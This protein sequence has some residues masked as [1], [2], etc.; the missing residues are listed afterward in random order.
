[1]GMS[2][3]AE[4]EQAGNLAKSWLSCWPEVFKFPAVPNDARATTYLELGNLR[5]M[6]HLELP[7]FERA[8][9]AFY[10]KHVEPVAA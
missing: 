9:M 8:L 1:M 6:D 3:P 5:A 10:V 7:D 4:V 2:L